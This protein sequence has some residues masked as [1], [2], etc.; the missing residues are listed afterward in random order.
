MTEDELIKKLTICMNEELP[1]RYQA[2]LEEFKSLIDRDL[3]RGHTRSCIVC[4]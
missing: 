4:L 2:K 3:M 1:E